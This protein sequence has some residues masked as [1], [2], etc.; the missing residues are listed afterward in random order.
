MKLESKRETVGINTV[1]VADDRSED[2]FSGAETEVVSVN[3]FLKDSF[4][5]GQ[6][7]R[8][9]SQNKVENKDQSSITYD[10]Q[11]S[12]QKDIKV[13]ELNRLDT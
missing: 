8:L 7:K 12:Q 3:D 9:N 5:D 11:F 1:A 6:S 4:L 2:S 10:R 13:I